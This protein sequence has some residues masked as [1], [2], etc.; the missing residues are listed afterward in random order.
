MV[1][2]PI[3]V[4]QTLLDVKS[5]KK[6]TMVAMALHKFSTNYIEHVG[7][8]LKRAQ[9]YKTDQAKKKNVLP[10]SID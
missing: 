7:I 8:F 5:L 6:T 9:D 1:I 4:I 2:Q 10:K 3:A